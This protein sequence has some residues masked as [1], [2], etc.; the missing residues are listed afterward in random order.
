MHLLVD[1]TL[2]SKGNMKIAINHI[3]FA[4]LII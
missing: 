1:S 3:F 4:L 2:E